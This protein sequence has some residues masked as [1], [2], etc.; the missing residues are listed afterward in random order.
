[1]RDS[2]SKR[3]FYFNNVTQVSQW[4]RPVGVNIVRINQTGS[5]VI[6]GNGVFE[7][8]YTHQPGMQSEPQVFAN[9]AG[10][11]IDPIKSYQAEV[12]KDKDHNADSTTMGESE[13]TPMYRNQERDLSLGRVISSS[14]STPTHTIALSTATFCSIVA[15][16]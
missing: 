16:S 13:R 1:M 15:E 14:R 11:M 6:L 8:D 2:K 3:L 5:A 12:F 9:Q 4:E 10:H 7:K